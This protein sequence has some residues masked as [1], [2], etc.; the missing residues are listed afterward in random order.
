MS[1]AYLDADMLAYRA[2]ERAYIKAD[3]NQTQS[4]TEI[5][6]F[7]KAKTLASNTISEWKNKARAKDVILAFTAPKN[8]R[9]RLTI[10]YN[11]KVDTAE[12]SAVKQFETLT[13]DEPISQGYLDGVPE[14]SVVFEMTEAA[15]GNK[16]VFNYKSNRVPKKPQGYWKLISYLESVYPYERVSNLEADDV[17]GMAASRSP[18][19]II[20]SLDKDIFTV[21]GFVLNPNK[22][23]R[24]EFNSEES[25]NRNWLTQVLTGDLT[26]GYQGI[27]NVG[28]VKAKRILA[29]VYSIEDMWEEVVTSYAFA[30]LTYAEA[31]LN[32]RLA[33]LLRDGEYD[34]ETHKIRL[35]E[36]STV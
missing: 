1:T 30:G 22:M 12:P 27:R 23:E 7:D 20:V 17:M 6:D 24:P 10:S 33:R 2:V 14:E 26:D 34:F 28:P 11:A 31:L 9:K 8:F 3:W 29:N 25:A 32:A 16:K 21:P 13:T 36:P 35:W 5:F 19:N 18:D 4:I 15:P